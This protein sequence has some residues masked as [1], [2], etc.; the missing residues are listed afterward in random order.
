MRRVQ[1]YYPCTGLRGD[2][3]RL[4]CIQVPCYAQI[5]NRGRAVDAAVAGVLCSGSNSS[6]NGLGQHAS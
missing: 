2:T 3:S 5:G 4:Y 6:S 1:L